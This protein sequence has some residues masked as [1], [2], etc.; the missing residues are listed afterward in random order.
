MSVRRVVTEKREG[1]PFDAES[2]N[3]E[4]DIKRRLGIEGVKARILEV[5]DI[6][7]LGDDEVFIEARKTIFSAAN[8]D[9]VTDDFSLNEGEVAF[10]VEYIPGTVDVHVEM[11]K[12]AY[13]ALSLAEPPSIAYSRI[14]AF[15][16]IKNEQ[17]FIRIK[18]ML[19][20]P[21]EKRIVPLSRP[22]TTIIIEE[23]VKAVEILDGFIEAEEADLVKISDDLGLAMDLDDLKCIHKYFKSEKRNP[24]ITEI[25]V[26]D[27]Y[28]SDHCRHT[29]FLT[30]LENI[31]IEDGFYS[32]QIKAALALVKKDFAEVA[33]AKGKDDQYLTL[34][35]IATLAMKK[36]RLEGKLPELVESA[37][38]NACTVKV[39]VEL[40]SGEIEEW[41]ILFKNETHNHPTERGPFGGAGTCL[42]GGIRDPLSGRAYVY[43]AMRITGAKDPREAIEQT[44]PGKLPQEDI[45]VGAAKGYSSYG[46]EI[47]TATGFVE[48][49]YHPGFVAKRME[50]GAVIAAGRVKDKKREVPVP[51]DAIILMGGTTGRDGVGGA[52]GSSVAQETEIKDVQA[53]NVQ[54]GNAP[55]EG[56]IH[57]AF[58]DPKISR[59]IKRCNDFGAGGVS[60][61]IGELSDGIEVNLDAVPARYA[62]L[63]GTELALSESQE[64]MAV[65]VAADEAEEFLANARKH[66]VSATIVGRV[67]DENRMVLIWRGEKIVNL[68]R[69]FLNSNGAIK[70]ANVRIK[71]PHNNKSAPD[72]TQLSTK[73]YKVLFTKSVSELNE[74]SQQGLNN[75]F[76]STAN[77]C[78]KFMLYGGKYQKTKNQAMVSKLPFVSSKAGTIMS[79][80]YGLDAADK[81][82]FHMGLYSTLMSI[83]KIVAMGGNPKEIYLSYQEYFRKLGNNPEAWGEVTAALL[84]GYVAQS[85]LGLASIGGKDSMS[86]TFGDINVPPVLVSFAVSKTDDIEKTISQEFK[87][88]DSLVYVLPFPNNMDGVPNFEAINDYLAKIHELIKSGIIK[89]C[90]ATGDETVATS[91]CKMAFGNMIG[92]DLTWGDKLLLFNK[93]YGMLIEVDPKYKHIM[94]EFKDAYVLAKTNNRQEIKM[95]GCLAEEP[96]LLAELLAAHEKTLSQIYPITHHEE[97]KD[98][99][100]V[101]AEYSSKPVNILRAAKPVATILSVLGTTGD[102]TVE[103]ALNQAGAETIMANYVSLTPQDVADF[104]IEF[105]ADIDRAHMLVFPGGEASTDLM[106]TAIKNPRVCEAIYNLINRDGLILGLGNG[107]KALVKSGLLPYGKVKELDALDPSILRNILGRH[108][109]KLVDTKVVSNKSPFL[110]SYDIG[111]VIT[112]PVSSSEGTLYI[113]RDQI[114]SLVKK[115]QVSLQYVDFDGKPTY[116]PNHNPFGSSNAIAGMSDETGHIFGTQLYLDRVPGV[117]HVNMQSTDLFTNGVNYFTGQTSVRKR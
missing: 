96:I 30:H 38:V 48:E 93:L 110:S 63:D 34:M 27:T 83:I 14:Y 59:A 111:E 101:S 16:G 78:G 53:A 114:L 113:T 12:E 72:F 1:S 75:M 109:A 88:T 99:E 61:A 9:I 95:P 49:L 3:L 94:D 24:T 32:D 66:N 50:L 20:N 31:E 6:E 10:R 18:N 11:V 54:N 92:F 29:T 60:I 39:N 13:K 77:A 17:D 33:K 67:T 98:E 57:K 44:L 28:W 8:E 104:M 73:D 47:G 64:R 4:A 23:D 15:T 56:D 107:F 55:L 112:G 87:S 115:G 21:I 82:P 102:K 52:T 106:L 80:G 69:D 5:H 74:C 79:Y 89:T 103:F 58:N 71:A 81:S 108:I 40:L 91:L 97:R 68:S 26:L 45:C 43:Q 46:N 51:G 19:V 85:A 62:G 84:G 42:G 36:A 70:K 105:A 116:D 41:E 90:Y 117:R 100:I 22:E 35:D 25:K 7:D 76:D 65:I 37:E 2:K 86:G